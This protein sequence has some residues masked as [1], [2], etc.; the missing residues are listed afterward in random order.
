[1]YYMLQKN[2]I[3]N[4]AKLFFKEPNKKYYLKQLAKETNR[5]HTS[6]YNALEQLLEKKLVSKTEEQ[7][8]SRTFPYYQANTDNETYRVY[9]QLHNLEELHRSGLTKYLNETL[10]PQVL[11]LFG[12]YQKGEDDEESDID[13][14]VQAPRQDIE[15][16]KY[17]KILGRKIELHFR[18]SFEEIATGLKNNLI[19]GTILKGYL[20]GY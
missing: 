3:Y 9:K 18:T 2:T 11:I 19:N 12:S 13:I 10:Q 17:E 15:L 20:Q 1:M 14:Y 7:R 16:E 4:V 5:A 6:I 8:G